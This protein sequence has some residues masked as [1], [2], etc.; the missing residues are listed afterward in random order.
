M[1]IRML[2]ISAIV[3][4]STAVPA[5]AQTFSPDYPFCMRRYTI[6]GEQIECN[7]G[8]L[9]QCTQSAAGL[10]ATCIPN[11]YAKA[12]AP[13][14]VEQQAPAPTPAPAGK[15]GKSARPAN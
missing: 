4:F 15:K 9:Q 8:S 12:A 14:P 1:R 10:P 5:L 13:A 7:F 11:P 3:T 6:D 2:V